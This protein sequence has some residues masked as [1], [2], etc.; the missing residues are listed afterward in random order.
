M[1]TRLFLFDKVIFIALFSFWLSVNFAAVGSHWQLPDWFMASEGN[2]QADLQK[3]ADKKA[4][5]VYLGQSGCP[6]CQALLQENW[7]K[8]SPLTD[9][10]RRHFNVVGFDIFSRKN[11]VLPDGNTAAVYAYAK[12][13]DATYSPSLLF[14]QPDG[15]KV[16]F[17]RGYYPPY[18]MGAALRYVAE[19]FYRQ[20]TFA[21][22]EARAAPLPTFD[23]EDLNDLPIAAKPPWILDRSRFPATRRLLA[24]FEEPRCH[25]CDILHTLLA[26][27]DIA[28]LAENFEIV[29]LHR[30]AD[31]PLISPN[32][33]R[34]D[35]KTWAETLAV[36]ASPTVIVFDENGKEI[37]RF[38]T[39]NDLY[40]LI[41][42][43]QTPK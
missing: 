16:F 41:D 27:V 43:L 33:Q 4:L 6:F 39:I 18:R 19:G 11:L 7:A 40:Q 29:Q 21:D 13:N 32:G 12:A 15:E 20:E 14:Y 23:P 22:Y 10:T 1:L 9:Y 34:Q 26:E 30:F 35:I 2:L 3:S 28:A 31:T 37:Q 42:Y 36:T 8:A 25:A 24:L 38:E 17:L 5:I